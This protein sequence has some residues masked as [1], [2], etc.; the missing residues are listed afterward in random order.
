MKIFSA[1]SILSLLIILSFSGCDKNE[2]NYGVFT[3]VAGDQSLIKVNYNIALTANPGVHIKI[4]GERVSTLIQTRYPYP[5]GG[6]GTLG[7]SRADY[8]TVNPGNLTVSIVIP[9]KGTGIDSVELF[10]TSV[11]AEAGKNYTLHVTD[12]AANTK[13]LLTTD[14]FTLPDT[15]TAKYRF[16]HLM[17]NVGA[18]DLYNGPTLVQANISYLNASDYFIL[19]NKAPTVNVWSV[20]LAGS[21]PTSTAV[22]TYT[23]ASTILNKRSYTVFA[24]GYSGRTD[25]VRK[26]YLGFFLI[27]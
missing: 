4:N 7:D 14:D 5:G 12:T 9:K 24:T 6:Y 8:L 27:R 25:A 19:A 22:A 2:I 3:K 10:K 26:P 23:S 17:P 18:L 11:A 20:R 15:A 16:V 13:S 1:I 21:A